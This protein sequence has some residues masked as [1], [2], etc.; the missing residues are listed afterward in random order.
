MEKNK[1][2]SMI[3]IVDDK[4][5]NLQVLGSILMNEKY[6]ISVAKNGLEAL[7]VVNNVV[8]DIILLDIMMPELD[9]FETCKRLKD[10][11]ETRHIPIIFL[12]AKIESE[13]IV[14]GFELGAVDYV[15]KPFKAKELLVRVNTHLDLKHSHERIRKNEQLLREANAAKDRFFSIIS[16]D[17]KDPFNTLV[18]FSQLLLSNVDKYPP[19]KIKEIGQYL[20]DSTVQASNLLEN[21]IQ[22]ARSQTGIIQWNPGKIELYKVINQ[23]IELLKDSAKKKNIRIKSEIGKGIFVY[24]DENMVNTVLRNLISNAIKYSEDKGDVLITSQDAGD[25]VEITVSDKGTGIKEEDLEKLFRIDIR[26]STKGTGGEEGSGLGLILCKKFIEKNGG[27]IWVKSENDSG[28]KFKFTLPGSK[29][30]TNSI[31]F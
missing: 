20:F 17:L 13:D 8:P 28:S 6:K 29:K 24:A 19:E 23:N 1:Q 22:W 21:L 3:L 27:E 16:R 26:F 18:G 14:K 31:I 2:N 7:K 9:G 15:T 12:T 5:E 11:P 25:A 30:N 4:Q 10:S